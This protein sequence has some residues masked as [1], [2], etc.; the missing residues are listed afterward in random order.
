[1]PRHGILTAAD[2][3]HIT[4][5]FSYA[6]TSAR[7]GATGLTTADVGK[8][9]R[10]TDTDTWWL[11]I[12]HDPVTWREIAPS[13]LPP[14]GYAQEVVVATTGGDYATIAAALASITDASSSKPYVITVKPGIYT[15]APLTMKAYVYVVGCC[16]DPAVIVASNNNSPLFTMVGASALRRVT[17]QGPTNDSA[18]YVAGGVYG[19]FVANVTFYSGLVAVECTGSNSN[20]VVEECKTYSG[21]GTGLLAESSGRIDC[22]NVLQYATTA[23]H[24]NGGTIWAHNSGCVGSTNGVCANNGGTIYP[25]V[26][27]CEGCTYGIRL[28]STGTNSVLDGPV[29]VRNSVT[30]DVYQE[31]ASGVLELSSAKLDMEKFSL[32]GP[33]NVRI[34]WISSLAYDKAFRVLA[35]AFKVGSIE[36]PRQAV[37]GGGG[38]EARGMVVLTTDSTASSTSDGGNLTDV[39]DDAKSPSGSTF[40]FQGT[41][42]NHTILVGSELNDGSDVIKHSGISVKTATGAVQ[43]SRHSFVAE[44]WNGSAWVDCGLMACN[45]SLFY[46]YGLDVFLRSGT[47]EC[48]RY[49]VTPETTWAKKTINGKNLYW[50]RIRIVTGLTSLPAFEWWRVR[51]D[52][53]KMGVDGTVVHSG[54]S[55][56]QLDLQASGN[57]FGEYGVVASSFSVGSGSVPAG[58]THQLKNCRLNGDNDAMMFQFQL[59]VGVDTSLPL[60]IEMYYKPDDVGTTIEMKLGVL[61]SEVVGVAVADLTGGS[62]PVARSNANTETL[63]SKAAY[64]ETNSSLDVSNAGKPYF[65]RWGPFDIQKYYEGDQVFLYMMASDIGLVD[66][67][68]LAINAISYKWTTGR[69]MGT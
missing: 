51:P 62:T 14:T 40:T 56:Y 43:V 45:S 52:A 1:M 67:D 3:I 63:T 5:A 64:T 50:S 55:R 8:I 39:S 47:T 59:P 46:R 2:G 61:P 7:T 66:L 53:T 36:Y 30:Y 6:N 60:Y 27:T 58:W 38:A 22:S 13:A 34:T 48:N 10:Q 17:I 15:E 26:V 65:V 69:K 4:H 9:A 24:A 33:N 57:Q 35:P 20:V 21:V 37:F 18:V 12:D 19:T 44:I 42:A 25:V 16:S 28:G 68:I 31:A 11:L 32:A 41:A 49:G 29:F 54:S 23:F